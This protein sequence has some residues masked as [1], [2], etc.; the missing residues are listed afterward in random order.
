MVGG[1]EGQTLDVVPVV[2]GRSPPEGG[3]GGGEIREG[4]KH[5]A[6]R[7]RGARARARGGSRAL[8]LGP[9]LPVEGDFL[10][11]IFSSLQKPELQ[12]IG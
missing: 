9:S 12:A 2:G 10:A 3:E 1:G 6:G 11:F 4:E 5:E 7:S 8:T